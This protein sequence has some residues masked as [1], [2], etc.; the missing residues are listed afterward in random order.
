MFLP[1]P[2]FLA[3]VV[4][5]GPPEAPPVLLLHSIGTTLHVWDPQVAALATRYRLIRPD[6][7]GHGLS[8]IVAGDHSMS[9]LAADQVAL[10]E[11]LGLEAAHVVGLSIGGRIAQTLAA[12]HPGRVASL[13]LL[14]TA[15]EFPPFDLWQGRIDAVRT[16][17]TQAIVDAVMPRWVVDPTADSSQGLKQMLL[18]TSG[19][20]YAGAAAALR[21]ARAEHVAGRITVPTTIVVGSLDPASPPEAAQA[22]AATIPGAVVRVIEGA[23]HIPTL[24]FAEPTTAAIAAHLDA[25]WV[26]PADAHAAGMAV[27]RAVLGAA[28]VARAQA[29][30]TPLDAAFQDWITRNVWGGVWTRPGLNRRTRSLLTLAMMAALGRHEEFALHVRATRNTGVTPEEIAEVLLGVGAYAG[31]PAANHALKIAKEVL[32]AG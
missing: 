13:L 21:D 31:V 1:L 22:M 4:I 28:H 7:R 10:L 27:R 15:M 12:E 30:A 24:E 3:H 5:E 25:Q 8:G 16:T 6:L 17:G 19:E 29:A 26:P 32:A 2:G 9:Q 23:S 14:D 18:A 11:A 20:G